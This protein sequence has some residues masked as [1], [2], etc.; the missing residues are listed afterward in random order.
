MNMIV[1]ALI[2]EGIKFNDLK[3]S[4]EDVFWLFVALIKNYSLENCFKEDME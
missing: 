4:E 2:Y 3:K 1:A